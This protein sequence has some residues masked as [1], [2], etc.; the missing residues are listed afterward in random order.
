[1]VGSLATLVAALSA[2]NATSASAQAVVDSQV[3]T[4]NTAI[5]AYNGAIVPP[6]IPI[7]LTGSSINTGTTLLTS[8]T[9]ASGS[10]LLL[11]SVISISS[12]IYDSHFVTGSL[13]LSG[14]TLINVTE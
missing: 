14:V 5:T 2:A 12:D 11:N 8:T 4:L 1:M 13:V 7:S 10:G 3:G 9:L 6:V